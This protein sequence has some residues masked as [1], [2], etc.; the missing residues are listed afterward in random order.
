LG[1]IGRPVD[2]ER[3]RRGGFVMVSKKGSDYLGFDEAIAIVADVY[4]RALEIATAFVLGG[5]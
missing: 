4:W 1:Y 2:T 5:R 3:I